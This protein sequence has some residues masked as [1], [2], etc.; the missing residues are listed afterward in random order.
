[1]YLITEFIHACNAECSADYMHKKCQWRRQGRTG[2]TFPP[3]PRKISKE[4]GI[5]QASARNE[6]RL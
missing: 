4:W 6:N 2:E 5:I 1:M 3:K